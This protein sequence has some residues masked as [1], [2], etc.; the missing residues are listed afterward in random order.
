MSHSTAPESIEIV[1]EPNRGWMR[2]DWR[3]LWEYRDLLLLLVRRELISKYKQTILGP[4]W[5]VINPLLTTAVFVVVFGKVAKIPTDNIP[6]VLFY[7]CGLL[8]WTYFSQVVTSGAATFQ[9]HTALFTK[10]YFPRLTVPLSVVIS[11]LCA[12]ALQFVTFIG[13]YVYYKLFVPEAATLSPTW[14]LIFLPLILVQ[15]GALSL[16]VTLWMSAAT[17][18]YRDLMHLNQFLMQLWMYATPIIYPLSQMPPKLMPFAWLNPM[19]AVEESIRLC[20]LGRGTVNS[21]QLTISVSITF[22][23]FISGIMVYQRMERTLADIA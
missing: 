16:G 7:L 22:L 19:C 3:A 4:A 13:I 21:T 20:L 5:F 23:I 10:V 2:I 11:T 6:P 17:A 12:F 9:A 8:G 15:I 1:I 14:R 18:K